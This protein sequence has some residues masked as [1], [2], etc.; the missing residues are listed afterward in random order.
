MTVARRKPI[1]PNAEIV[2]EPEYGGFVAGLSELLEQSR[3]TAARAVNSVLTA[4]YWE[5]GRRIVEFEQRGKARAGYGKALLER[6]AKDLTARSVEGFPNAT[7]SKCGRFTSVG[8]FSQRLRAIWR[9]G[10]IARRRLAIL[11]LL[12]KRRH[13]LRYSHPRAPISRESLPG[14]PEKRRRCLR[15]LRCA[16]R[17][18][19]TSRT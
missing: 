6:L 1:R 3:R 4:T 18:S 8:K 7:S 2:Q 11:L 16:H 19:L 17:R 9:L 5:I 13:R 15:N 10:R 14:G 12:K